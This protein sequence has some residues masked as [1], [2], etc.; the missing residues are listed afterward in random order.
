M[1]LN[2]FWY[3]Y[4]IPFSSNIK[5]D[6][7]LFL[8]HICQLLSHRRTNNTRA[9]K[10]KT[11]T[12]TT[13]PPKKIEL[14]AIFRA[15]DLC[16]DGYDIGFGFACCL[17]PFIRLISVIYIFYLVSTS[18]DNTKNKLNWKTLKWTKNQNEGEYKTKLKQNEKKNKQI[19]ERK[20]LAF[21]ALVVLFCVCVY[22]I[23][24]S[25]FGEKSFMLAIEAS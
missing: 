20:S 23:F 25:I 17:P 3:A 15:I 2:V 9:E 11:T 5:Y 18:F 10:Y 1:N 4:F 12:T 21:A 14:F 6:C 19:I 16:F 13:L 7:R 24:Y 22:S 8:L